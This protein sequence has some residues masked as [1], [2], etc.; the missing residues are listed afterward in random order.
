MEDKVSKWDVNDRRLRAIRNEQF[1]LVLKGYKYTK[2][3]EEIEGW[4][5]DIE[6]LLKEQS[7]LHD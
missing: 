6:A 3:D 5:K 4:E 7:D 1:R 2:S